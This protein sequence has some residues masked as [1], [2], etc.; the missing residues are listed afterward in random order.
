M[1]EKD[2]L[3]KEKLEH[4]GLFNF[5][6]LYSYAYSW[7][8]EESFGVT[9]EKYSETH[10]G[11][12]KNVTVEWKCAKGMSDYFKIEIG[13]K[14]EMQGLIDVEVEQEGKK[15]KT[16]KGRAS[17]EIKG[18]LVQD[19][20]SK[21]DETPTYKFMRELYMKYIIPGRVDTMEDLTKGAV[22]DFKEKL[23]VF[24]ESSG[25]R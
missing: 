5:D 22:R 13:V 23:K 24:L 2:Q 25:R 14:M 21:W 9:E 3:I 17:I 4:V 19:P 18:T 16:N 10:T 20:S 1:A 15:K 12:G 8:K 11:S 7:F 6:D